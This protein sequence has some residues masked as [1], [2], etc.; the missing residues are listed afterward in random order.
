M[1]TRLNQNGAAPDIRPIHGISIHGYTV[2]KEI[3]VI[4]KMTI[5]W[6]R[7][8]NACGSLTGDSPDPTRAATASS[9][10]SAKKRIAQHGVVR[11]PRIARQ[12][13]PDRARS[14][15]VLIQ[16]A[17]RT[18]QRPQRI[19][20]RASIATSYS[21]AGVLRNRTPTG[22]GL[23]FWRLCFGTKRFKNAPQLCQLFRNMRKTFPENFVRTTGAMMRLYWG[24]RERVRI[25]KLPGFHHF[26]L[27]RCEGIAVGY[28]TI[29]SGSYVGVPV[30]SPILRPAH[31][32]KVLFRRLWP[33]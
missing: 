33:G 22:G 5:A 11:K 26:N 19:D 14:I 20:F 31:K 10:P 1:N 6:R 32:A 3:K 16:T 25:N 7:V 15:N 30:S 23:R 27:S 4:G 29:P 8:K 9:K 21:W 18:V 12:S 24:S 17:T 2:S 28:P 13:C